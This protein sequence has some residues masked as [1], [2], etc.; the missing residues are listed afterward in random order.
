MGLLQK[1][2]DWRELYMKILTMVNMPRHV[3]APE[4]KAVKKG[5]QIILLPE[6][7]DK[8]IP[9]GGYIPHVVINKCL[10][11]Y[12]HKCKSWLYTSLF[13]KNKCTSD[14]LKDCCKYC[15]NK[16]RRAHYAKTKAVTQN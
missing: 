7:Y 4:R 9:T 14:G 11:K 13:I 2:K 5:N 15:D 1:A 10:C 12:C 16:R 3:K 6:V 8:I